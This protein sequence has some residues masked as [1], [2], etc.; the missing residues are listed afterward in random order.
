[1]I[2]SMRLLTF[3]IHE[4]LPGTAFHEMAA[5]VGDDEAVR[6][7][8]A[9]VLSTLRQ[10]KG[11]V[12]TRIRIA[13]HPPDADEALRFWLLPRLAERWETDHG[14]FR[15][16]G[17]EIDFGTP[18]LDAVVW[19]EGDI[20]CPDL[21]ARW[22]HAA[23]IGLERGLHGVA[24]FSADGE[25]CFRAGHTDAELRKLPELALV[26][27]DAEWQRALEGPLGATLRKAWEEE[28]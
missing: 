4:P 28:V 24:A 17:W 13:A 16:Q 27:N 5:A 8:K 26:R 15:T 18:A 19:A 21:G 20:R 22:V 10:L 7:Y 6:R 25:L 9:V 14:V 1:M 12:E 11:L 23:M 2:H 3:T